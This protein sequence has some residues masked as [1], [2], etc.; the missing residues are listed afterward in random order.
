VPEPVAAATYYAEALKHRMAVGSSIVVYDLGAGTF[1]ASVVRRTD[2]GFTTVALDGR[3]DLGGLD[4]DA[5]L[6]E[7]LGGTY[8]DREGWKRL[9]NPTSV[10]E[11]RHF[12]DFQEEIRGAKER[13]SRHQQSDFAIPLLD[14]EA[15]LTR[16]ELE[17]IAQ[18]HLEQTIRVTQAVIRAAGLD[19]AASAGVFLVGGASRMPL[20]ATMLHR[21]LGLAPTVLDQPEIVVAEGSV[22]WQAGADGAT[23]P[24]QRQFI[25]PVTPGANP[26]APHP[27]PTPQA[28]SPVAPVTEPQAPRQGYE[29]RPSPPDPVTAPAQPSPAR[30]TLPPQSGQYSPELERLREQARSTGRIQTPPVTVT[31]DDTDPPEPPLTEEERQRRKRIGTRAV[32]AIILVNVLVI[33]GLAWYFGPYREASGSE[34]DDSGMSEPAFDP[35]LVSSDT[36][37]LAAE[38]VAA[39]DEPIASLTTAETEDGLM[40]FSAEA[41]GLV[42]QWSMDTG[43]LAATFTLDATIHSLHATFDSDGGPIVVAVDLDYS[44]HVWS[45]ASGTFDYAGTPALAEERDVGRVSVGTVLGKPMLG[46]VNNT[47]MELFDL[48]ES[49]S[50]GVLPIPEGGGWTNFYLLGDELGYAVAVHPDHMLMDIDVVYGETVGL[51]EDTGE[52]TADVDVD[53]LSVVSYEGT[54]HAMLLGTDGLL[55]FWDIAARAPSFDPMALDSDFSEFHNEVVDTATGPSI[56]FIDMGKDAYVKSLDTW[57]PIALDDSDSGGFMDFAT[58]EVD[59]SRFAVTGDDAGNIQFWSL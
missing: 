9:M 45:P 44:A 57:E 23:F 5:A 30:Q 12:R 4:I 1:D 31:G 2:D 17:A 47:E 39:H 46:L 56:M 40:L 33:A 37:T 38:I 15:H 21:A 59:G 48:E 10:E 29:Y 49:A 34:W 13:L 32:V 28:S 26:G 7:H 8:G 11:L 51:L 25:A 58:V 35:N 16:T 14:V 53:A 20:V 19:V 55:Y 50:E 27:A 43:E 22:L 6:I 42:R 3:S 36:G 18:P 24:I 52:W 54:P 41:G